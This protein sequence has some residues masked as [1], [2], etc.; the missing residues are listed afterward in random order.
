LFGTTVA[1]IAPVELN[2]SIVKA[3][4]GA[5][6]LISNVKLISELEGLG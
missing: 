2:N 3:S 6:P 1:I 4:G 5:L